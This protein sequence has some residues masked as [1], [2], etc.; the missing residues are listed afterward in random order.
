MWTS[1]TPSPTTDKNG[2]VKSIRRCRPG[3][4]T[5]RELER[6]IVWVN[7]LLRIFWCPVNSFFLRFVLVNLN[8]SASFGLLDFVCVKSVRHLRVAE[9]RLHIQLNVFHLIVSQFLTALKINRVILPELALA[10]H[11]H[12]LETQKQRIQHGK[13]F[14]ADCNNPIPTAR[15]AALPNCN[16]CIDCQTRHEKEN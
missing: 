12:R 15:L 9:Y 6:N 4:I 8:L 7:I 11:Y 3:S 13:V 16:R 1:Y 14:C 5:P 2:M 10:S